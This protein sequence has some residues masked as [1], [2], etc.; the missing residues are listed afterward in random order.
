MIQP[1]SLLFGYETNAL[2]HYEVEQDPSEIVSCENVLRRA[3][4]RRAQLHDH[5]VSRFKDEYLNCLRERHAY[6]VRKHNASEDI[7]KVGD[8]V[9]IH[10][11]DIPRSQ[12]KLGLVTE[13]IRG[14]D[15]RV[16]AVHLRTSGNRKTSRAISKLYPLEINVGSVEDAQSERNES[17]ASCDTEPLRRSKRSTVSETRKKIAQQLGAENV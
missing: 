4:L 13:L 17:D 3:E 8:I 12:W 16:R 7:I 11:D 15:S 6:Q 1:R 9:L 14:P 10:D 2:P 5:F